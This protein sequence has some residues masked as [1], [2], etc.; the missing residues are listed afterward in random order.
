MTDT[1]RPGPLRRT[2]RRWSIFGGAAVLVGALVGSYFDLL[3]KLG[4]GTGLNVGLPTGSP[5]PRDA[6][7]PSA[8]KSSSPPAT[9]DATRPPETQAT[10]L[11]TD[12][13][14]VLHVVVEANG[15][16]LKRRTAS[17]FAYDP[18][19]LP[20][21]LEAVK[22]T[23]GNPDGLRVVVSVRSQTRV[24]AFRT[25][26]EQLLAAGLQDTEVTRLDDAKIEA[27]AGK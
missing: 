14:P 11:P 12:P 1:P 10:T 18:V 7:T 25:F 20:A 15:L 22:K 4:D 19:E 13:Q 16:S 2:V 6:G 21:L 8:K 5:G 3:P 9:S 27:D 24:N 17:G 23:T 26:R